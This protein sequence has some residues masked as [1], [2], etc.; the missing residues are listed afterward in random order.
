MWPLISRSTKSSIALRRCS[1]HRRAALRRPHCDTLRAENYPAQ[2]RRQRPRRRQIPQRSATPHDPS[3]PK[4]TSTL[5]P[6]PHLLQGSATHAPFQRLA[7]S[8]GC[9]SENE[10]PP[11]ELAQSEKSTEFFDLFPAFRDDQGQPR[12]D[13]FV[14]NGTHFSP[15]G[16]AAVRDC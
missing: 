16:Y 14:E 11:C 7:G 8:P 4:V 6:H 10:Q 13:V 9:D 3:S 2:R 5:P 1:A 12:A 15:K